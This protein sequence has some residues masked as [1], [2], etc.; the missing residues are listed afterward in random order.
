MSIPIEEKNYIK[1]KK[2]D[3][4]RWLCF[5]ESNPNRKKESKIVEKIRK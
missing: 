4:Y 2:L 1:N 3:M 5:L